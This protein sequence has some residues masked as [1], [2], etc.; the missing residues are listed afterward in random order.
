MVTN[1][2]AD[3]TISLNT[4]NPRNFA[5]GVVSLEDIFFEAIDPSETYGREIWVSDVWYTYT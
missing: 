3:A 1:G 4:V 5:H 2:T